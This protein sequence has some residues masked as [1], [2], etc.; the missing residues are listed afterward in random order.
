M[1]ADFLRDRVEISANH[2]ADQRSP[3]YLRW[4][5]GQGC[6]FVQ[7]NARTWPSEYL[8]TTSGQYGCSSDNRVA[9]VCQMRSGIQMNKV[10]SCGGYNVNGYSS[11][12]CNNVNTNCGSDTGCPLPPDYQVFGNSGQGGWSDA[13]DAVPVMLGYWNCQ[14]DAPSPA[15]LLAQR[16]MVPTNY[17]Q[18]MPTTK[19]A[20][21][22]GG[23]SHCPDC[24]CFTSSLQELSRLA[25]NPAFPK[26]GMCY[27]ANCYKA[28]YLQVTD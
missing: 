18:V 26:Y 14:D 12:V 11:G 23:Q 28:D 22:F 5:R 3:G 25:F 16:S 4:G 10:Y 19:E 2:S 1:A 7:N 8:C 27:R 17:T 20:G 6:A 24:R 21:L 13:M 9:S 15:T